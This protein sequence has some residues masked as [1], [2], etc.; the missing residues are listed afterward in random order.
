MSQTISKIISVNVHWRQGSGSSETYHGGVDATYKVTASIN[1]AMTQLS[2]HT[3]CQSFRLYDSSVTGGDGAYNGIA[4]VA[5][6]TPTHAVRA[7]AL[8][9]PGFYNYKLAGPGATATPGVQNCKDEMAKAFDEISWSS[10]SPNVITSAFTSDGGSSASDGL[11]VV[12]ESKTLTMALTPSSFDQDGNYI[13]SPL[14]MVINRFWNFGSPP[15]TGTYINGGT[16]ATGDRLSVVNAWEIGFN[17]FDY[18]VGAIRKNFYVGRDLQMN[19]VSTNRIASSPSSYDHEYLDGVDGKSCIKKQSGWQDIKNTLNP[20]AATIN[21]G[22]I[23][24]QTT[25]WQAD[26]KSGIDNS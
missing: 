8:K 12:G 14:F 3:V 17:S 13:D 20:H 26:K 21:K 5:L 15:F 10:L 24:A 1:D 9:N 19:W 23:K 4:I 2:L 18:Y 11:D 7:N 16:G 6:K 25:G 22:H